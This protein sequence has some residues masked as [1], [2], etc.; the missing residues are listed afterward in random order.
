M[1]RFLAELGC[2]PAQSGIL[3]DVVLRL[4][5][6]GA[7]DAAFRAARSVAPKTSREFV[8]AMRAIAA[9]YP[10]IGNTL[11]ARQGRR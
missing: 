6:I 8:V 11:V 1:R 5:G 7:A 10:P 3:D 2:P 9:M 4:A